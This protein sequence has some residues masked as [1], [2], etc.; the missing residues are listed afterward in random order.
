MATSFL[1][2]CTSSVD[3]MALA[4]GVPCVSSTAGLGWVCIGLGEGAASSKPKG[5]G[6]RVGL[7]GSSSTSFPLPSLVSNGEIASFFFPWINRNTNV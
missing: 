5:S 1:K 2:F 4:V 7:W 6:L 3:R